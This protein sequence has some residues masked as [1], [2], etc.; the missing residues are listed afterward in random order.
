M[1]IGKYELTRQGASGRWR[2]FWKSLTHT[3]RTFL[4]MLYEKPQYLGGTTTVIL[5]LVVIE[6]VP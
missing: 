3:C 5:G 4:S 2:Y 1:K 6:K